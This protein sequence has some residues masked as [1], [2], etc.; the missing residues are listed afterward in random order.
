MAASIFRWVPRCLVIFRV[1]AFF[2]YKS[3]LHTAVCRKSFKQRLG[4]ISDPGV[5]NS[6]PPFLM[7]L[8]I[9]FNVFWVPDNWWLYCSTSKTMKRWLVKTRSL[10][11]S[12]TYLKRVTKFQNSC[13]YTGSRGKNL[14]QTRHR[15]QMRERS[16]FKWEWIHWF[17]FG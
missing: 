5:Y 2:L 14:R 1:L 17:L 16:Q 4:A 15:F 10:L 8:T 3:M 13:N 9:L 6:C 12:F 7:N 11:K